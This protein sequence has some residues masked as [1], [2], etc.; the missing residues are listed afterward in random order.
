MGWK[1]LSG[2]LK[3]FLDGQARDGL[4]SKAIEAGQVMS[5]PTPSMKQSSTV[6]KSSEYTKPLG[7]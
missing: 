4:L 5:G 7:V 2:S 3:T 6:R 1:S